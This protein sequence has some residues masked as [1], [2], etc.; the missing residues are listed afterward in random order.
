MYDEFSTD[1]DRFVSWP[2]RLAYE[3]PFIQKQAQFAAIEGQPCRILDTACGTGMHAIG[4][5]QSG[6]KVVG[7][8]LSAG[9]IE[10]ARRN[11][12][13]VGLQVPFFVSGFTDLP[14]AIPRDLQPFDL[15][16]CLGNSL[17]H[18]ESLADLSAALESFAASLRTGGHLL[19]QSRN[20]D[21]VMAQRS[22]WMEPQGYKEGSSEWLFV[23]FYDFEPDGSIRFHIL[24]MKRDGGG[25]WK[26]SIS[27]T[28]LLPLRQSELV[29]ALTQVG[30]HS[31]ESFGDMQEGAFDPAS[32]GN[33]V[34]V[35]TRI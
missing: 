20:F 19:I 15:V 5:A 16:T 3:L 21:A 7:A 17:P 4:L 10:R 32:S 29:S 12:A 24:T 26:Q 14:R 28:R 22:R 2:G 1:Y 30:F 33:L 31:I 35:A 23:R 34:L 6:A 27:S 18:V 25:A 8:D 9:M 11:A 13:E